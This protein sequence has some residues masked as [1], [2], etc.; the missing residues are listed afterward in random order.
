MVLYFSGTG[1]SRYIAQHLAEQLE[2]E[3][4]SM[5]RLIRQR[6]LDPYNAQYAFSSEDPFVIVCPTYCW[7][8]PKVVEEFLLDSRF[9]GNR[10]MYFLLTCGSGTGQAK[11]H[12]EK[13]CKELSMEY[14]GLTSILMPENYIT[15]FHAP[16]ADEAVGIIR[17]SKPQVENI[18]QQ[19]LIHHSVK[20]SYSGPAM[21][22]LLYRLFYKIFVTDKKFRVKDNCIGCSACAKLCPMANIRMNDRKPVWQG[23]CTQCQACIAV[24]PVDAIEFGRR[25]KGKRRYYLFADGRQKFPNDKPQASAA[26]AKEPKR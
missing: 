13:I 3:L 4:V 15:L 26:P 9:L 21:P 1:N 22:E 11:A 12:A 6:K 19:I 2:D 5:N 10:E 18:A 8:V 17:A 20:D 16:E 24:C 25:A 7:H 23:N 14:M